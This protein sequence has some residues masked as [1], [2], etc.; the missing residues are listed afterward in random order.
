MVSNHLIFFKLDHFPSD[1]GEHEKYLS[2]HHVPPG[3][4]G[5][6]IQKTG[7]L[8]SKCRRV[9]LKFHSTKTP[10]KTVMFGGIATNKGC[11]DIKTQEIEIINP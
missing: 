10:W 2:C 5:R 7:S 11:N 6:V 8:S 1:W 4:P 9:D 3:S